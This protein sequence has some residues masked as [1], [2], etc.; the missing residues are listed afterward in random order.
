V[1]NKKALRFVRKEPA[2]GFIGTIRGKIIGDDQ[3]DLLEGLLKDRG[4]AAVD[5]FRTVVVQHYNADDNFVRF[6]LLSIHGRKVLASRRCVARNLSALTMPGIGQDILDP[7]LI[8]EV[9]LKCFADAFF[10]GMGGLP[11]EFLIYFC[12]IDCVAAVMTGTVFHEGD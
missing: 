5:P 12:G 11:A 3:L 2:G 8:G 7:R 6:A 1:L 9:P 10:E 4:D